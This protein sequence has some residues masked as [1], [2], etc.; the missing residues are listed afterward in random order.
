MTGSMQAETRMKHEEEEGVG[1]D[2]GDDEEDELEGA[3]EVEAHVVVE[4]V[5][6]RISCCADHIFKP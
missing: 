1:P 6:L 4:E 5:A 2:D 3:G